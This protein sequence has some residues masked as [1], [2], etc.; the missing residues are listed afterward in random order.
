MNYLYELFENDRSTKAAFF[1]DP[2]FGFFLFTEKYDHE[3]TLEN[4]CN[5]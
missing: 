5:L 1:E 3:L 4:E 2:N